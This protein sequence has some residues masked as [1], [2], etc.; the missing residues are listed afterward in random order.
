MSKIIK[1]VKNFHVACM[2]QEGRLTM[3]YK[4]KKGFAARSYGIYVAEILDF[5][6]EIIMDA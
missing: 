6:K 3:Q 2:T 4:V 1:N 5:P